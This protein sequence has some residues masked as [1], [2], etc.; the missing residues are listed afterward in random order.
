M[1]LPL[2]SLLYYFLCYKTLSR[3]FC[4]NKGGKH[5]FADSQEML[6]QAVSRLPKGKRVILLADRGFVHTDLMRR[7]TQSLGWHYRIRLKDNSWIYCPRDGRA[8]MTFVLPH[9]R[10][11]NLRWPP[12][13]N[14][15]N[16]SIVLN[17]KSK[18][19]DTR[20]ANFP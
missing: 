15:S 13:N 19:T 5:S 17:F 3:L 2:F 14:I 18:L 9:I 12:E 16:A 6:E 4:T 1:L 20:L 7:L 8:L 10:T 11:P